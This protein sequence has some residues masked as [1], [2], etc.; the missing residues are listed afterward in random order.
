MTLPRM[1]I[2]D[3]WG[4]Q[5]TTT[6]EESSSTFE[7]QFSQQEIEPDALVAHA[8]F[9]RLTDD[10][11]ARLAKAKSQLKDAVSLALTIDQSKLDDGFLAVLSTQTVA[12]NGPDQPHL[13]V[14]AERGGGHPAGFREHS[15]IDEFH[16]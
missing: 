15:D 13:F 1:H 11:K 16:A 10:A 3:T 4:M 12:A 8:D 5:P 9:F 14:I 2:K 7:T 6:Y